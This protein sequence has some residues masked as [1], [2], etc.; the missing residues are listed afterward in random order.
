MEFA[1]PADHRVKLK[2]SEKRD[3]CLDLARELKKNPME[4]ESDDDTNCNWHVRYSH[5]K[6]GTGTRGL[7]N[8]AVLRFEET[9]RSDSSGKPSANDG[10]KNS[11]MNK[12]IISKSCKRVMDNME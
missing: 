1:V 10:V 7:G 11:Q 5:E 3:K 8:K 4:H 12:I 9:C 6:I 2:K